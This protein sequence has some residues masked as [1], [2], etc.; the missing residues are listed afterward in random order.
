MIRPK[1]TTRDVVSL[2]SV[3][4]VP[5]A[6]LIK[7]ARRRKYCT[8]HYHDQAS[9]DLLREK[10]PGSQHGCKEAANSAHSADNF[11][12]LNIASRPALPEPALGRF[13]P[14]TQHERTKIMSQ[15]ARAGGPALWDKILVRSS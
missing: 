7:G 4:T 5:V 15:T 14:E 13:W 6:A 1:T 11:R 12:L 3:V 9:D 8:A 2:T 10:Q